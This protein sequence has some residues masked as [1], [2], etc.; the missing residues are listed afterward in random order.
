M[1]IFCI[2]E[3]V[4]E[5]VD[6]VTAKLH[7]RCVVLNTCQTLDD[8]ATAYDVLLGIRVKI[9]FV[10]KRGAKLIHICYNLAAIVKS[11][12]AKFLWSLSVA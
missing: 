4:I 3:Y 8:C 12:F 6:F 2:N 11:K 5:V 9:L 10:L 1:T 7:Y